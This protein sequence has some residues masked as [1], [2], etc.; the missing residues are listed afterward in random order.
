MQT[1]H[2]SYHQSWHQER[3]EMKKKE[4][5]DQDLN[6][7]FYIKRYNSSI[8]RR[9]WLILKIIETHE[10]VYAILDML[11]FGLLMHLIVQMVDQ[12]T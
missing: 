11:L 6:G 7:V 12:G 2:Y 4:V 10:T 3:K 5:D 8:S 9:E 1:D